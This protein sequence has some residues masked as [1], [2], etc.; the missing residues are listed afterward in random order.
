MTAPGSSAPADPL[1]TPLPLDRGEAATPQPRDVIARRYTLY[2]ELG[3]GSFG[4]V[5]LARDLVG[6]RWVALKRIRSD[7]TG[8]TIVRRRM[9]REARAVARLD[10][11]AIVRLFD[12]GED[13]RRDPYVVMELVHGEPLS[14]A[15][16]RVRAAS[17]LAAWLDQLLDALAYA[18][19]RGVVHRD[20]KPQNVL[21]AFDQPAPWGVDAATRQVSA[22]PEPA[23][24]GG[25][26][27]NGLGAAARRLKVLDFGLARVD[28]DPDMNITGTSGETVGTPIYM[29]P[30]QATQPALVGP[31]SDLYAV[32][33]LAWEMFCGA[34]PFQGP[35]ATATVLQHVRAPLPAFLPRAALGA[36]AALGPVLARALSKDPRRRFA[37]AAEMRR[38]LRQV[39]EADADDDVE[40]TLV[41]VIA[42]GLGAE[43]SG[44]G[45]LGAGGELPSAAYVTQLRPAEPPLVGREAWQRVLWSK[46]SEVCTRQRPAFV[47][48]DG[49]PGV[50]KY[51]LGRWLLEM[52]G[53]TGYLT[54]L[55]LG[56]DAGDVRAVD[57]LAVALRRA[58]GLGPLPPAQPE[59]AVAEAL[60]AIGAERAVDA[61]PLAERLWSPPGLQR[62]RRAFAL[63]DLLRHLTSRRPALVWLG[64]LA[65]M[66]AALRATAETLLSRAFE[67]GLPVLVLGTIDD[68][69]APAWLDPLIGRSPGACER[70]RLPPLPPAVTWSLLSRQLPEEPAHLAFQAALQQGADGNALAAGQLIRWLWE[71]GAV[72]NVEGVLAWKPPLPTLPTGLGSLVE[73]RLTAVFARDPDLLG[74][75]LR[76]LAASLA[77]FGQ[78][79]TVGLAERLATRLGHSARAA[80]TLVE[81]LADGG[82]LAE[83]GRDGLSFAHPIIR[84]TLAGGLDAPGRLRAHQLSA[85]LLLAGHGFA[86]EALV[87]HLSGAGQTVRALGLVCSAVEEA[88]RAG[89][90]RWAEGLLTR[91]AE[92]VD[93][94]VDSAGGAMHAR[95]ALLRARVAI[96]AGRPDDALHLVG[97]MPPTAD[98]E[99]LQARDRVRAEAFLT[100]GDAV[101]AEPVLA[102]A[103]ARAEKTAG[104]DPADEARLRWLT[105]RCHLARGRLREARGLLIAAR[106]ELAAAGEAVAEA[107]ARLDLSNLAE[108]AGDVAAA[109]RFARDAAALGGDAADADVTADAA[110]RT[111]DLLRR[112]GQSGEAR[113]TF[114]LA[115]RRYESRGAL[116]GQARASKGKAQMERLLGDH[117]ES[118]QAYERARAVYSRLGDTAQAGQC[119]MHQGWIHTRAGELDRAER[120]FLR[121]LTAL[122]AAE[123]ALRVGLIFGF[124]ARL[125]HYR[126]DRE[127]R[128]RRLTEAL[129]ID[130]ARCMAVP[131]WPR[132]LEG[133]AEALV[134]EGE[135]D[136]AAPLLQRAAEVWRV[137]RSADDEARCRRGHRE[138]SGG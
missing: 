100:A 137:L 111:A 37:D 59:A 125:A 54:P 80:A 35:N 106:G 53:Q 6:Q 9:W 72:V 121:A 138:L 66:D 49:A 129:R 51:R 92:T 115:L 46:V 136:Q 88:L 12:Y 26:D 86:L 45:S 58:L 96:E 118:L 71:S 132:T 4:R 50:G 81:R 91:F 75:D 1:E 93:L 44:T 67:Q 133:L 8:D 107:R 34:P 94:E 55:D 65:D 124:L 21:V 11:P 103:L 83:H 76:V 109:L 27:P 60:H 105:G 14:R 52:A 47:L 31:A 25:T 78:S 82:I 62:P 20:L 15:A 85:E 17:T 24:A 108:A 98:P 101:S 84:R 77:V 135:P 61:A 99:A 3:T 43:A 74:E 97:A 42:G 30:E 41:T 33:I 134:R 127:L 90:R 7:Q 68:G 13:E 19:A 69:N 10:H 89:D 122:Q 22:A 36:P 32:G 23:D 112:T 18:H 113:D 39:F 5:F 116:L 64:R 102:A 29:S 126:G 57:P 117:A 131:E 114:A 123:D 2:R 28:E 70:L 73:A 128:N 119:D 120:C 48:L 110:L 87:T 130:A 95:V 56:S 104:L 63:M 38:A 16:E 79:F 40:E